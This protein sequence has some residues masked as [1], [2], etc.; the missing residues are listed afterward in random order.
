MMRMREGGAPQVV[1]KGRIKMDAKRATGEIFP[2]EFAIQSADT[3]EG[4]IFISFLRDI[5]Y[6]VAAE[7]DLVAARDR[8]LAGEK[9]KT[10]FLRMFWT[11]QN[12]TPENCSFDLW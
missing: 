8:A 11:S 6:R 7:R 10:D 9:A 2:V 1:G 4:Q 12:M 3:D 5:S